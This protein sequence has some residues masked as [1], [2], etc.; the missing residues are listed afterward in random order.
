MKRTSYISI[1]M[2]IFLFT[3]CSFLSKDYFLENRSHKTF[4]LKKNVLIDFKSL[5][6]VFRNNLLNK[7]KTINVSFKD[8]FLFINDIKNNTVYEIHTQKIKNI[9][10]NFFNQKNMCFNIVKKKI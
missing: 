9:I 7:I 5:E 4:F 6:N 10:I 2:S 8:N 3:H 1:L